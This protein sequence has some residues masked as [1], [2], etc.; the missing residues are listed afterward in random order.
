MKKLDRN[1]KSLM[2]RSTFVSFA[3]RFVQ[4]LLEKVLSYGVCTVLIDFCLFCTTFQ[5]S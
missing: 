5:I 3:N 1:N 2:Q 4:Q